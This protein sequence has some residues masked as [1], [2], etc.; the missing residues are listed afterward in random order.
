MSHMAHVDH[1]GAGF[2]DT[3]LDP[4]QERCIYAD[5]GRGIHTMEALKVTCSSSG[6]GLQ[7]FYRGR[8]GEFEGHSLLRVH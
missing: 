6:I 2:E 7:Q 3:H 4:Q 5:V 1:P 8:K